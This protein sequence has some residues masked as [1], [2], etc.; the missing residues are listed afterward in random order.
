MPHS[1]KGDAVPHLGS[2]DVR[3]VV[4][5]TDSVARRQWGGYLDEAE[6]NRAAVAALGT[7]QT[8][9]QNT[10]QHVRVLGPR[11]VV[12]AFDP[13]HDEPELLRTVVQLL[14][15]AALAAGGRS[16][17]AEIVTAEERIAA[18]LQQL[19]DIDV[20][21][22]TAEGIAKS[23]QT[24][25]SRCAAIRTGIQRLLDEALSALAGVAD[26]PVVSQTSSGSPARPGESYTSRH[27]RSHAACAPE[28]SSTSATSCGF[29]S[30][31]RLHEA[32]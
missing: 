5:V 12:L 16:G 30:R 3:V 25:E 31:P 11:R 7:V 22:R 28:D 24:I 10:G 21:K 23:A 18:A 14:R 2:A 20:I 9:E 6:R 32:A 26:R 4:E 13:E 8:P 17:A 19:A 15:A 1:K 27:A 29:P